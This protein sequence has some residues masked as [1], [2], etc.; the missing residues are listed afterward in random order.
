M[1]QTQKTTVSSGLQNPN[2]SLYSQQAEMFSKTHA[3]RYKTDHNQMMVTHG[4]E[5]VLIALGRLQALQMHGRSMLEG[6]FK[7]R[8]FA[9]LLS[10]FQSEIFYPDSIEDMAGAVL[11]DSEG[12]QLLAQKIANLTH[13][14]RY[15][16]ADLLELS[17][18]NQSDERD[19]FEVA[20]SLGLVFAK[21]AN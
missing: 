12:N 1:Q 10:C 5:G 4:F 21:A 2:A 19:V 6:K 8:E 17:W 16:L 13:L 20:E 15:A 14:E 9:D 7:K 11:D 3:E 18:H